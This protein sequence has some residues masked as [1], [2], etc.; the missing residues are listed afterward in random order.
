[1]RARRVKALA[2]FSLQD[3]RARKKEG[4][5]QTLGPTE[6]NVEK[7]I[8]KICPFGFVPASER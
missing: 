5:I 3:E 2:L 7:G 4:I 1:L 8:T 6:R